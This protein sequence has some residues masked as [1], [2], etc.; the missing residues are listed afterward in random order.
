[1]RLKSTP[2][3]VKIRQAYAERDKSLDNDPDCP[4]LPPE[5]WERAEIGRFYRPRKTQISFR[6]DDEILD[7][8]KSKGE[9]HLTR[10]NGILLERMISEGGGS[11]R[12]R[13]LSQRAAQNGSRTSGPK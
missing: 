10:I 7:W 8:L 3:K 4:T 5:A 13:F 9:G 1:M 12:T 2:R 11:P 6:I